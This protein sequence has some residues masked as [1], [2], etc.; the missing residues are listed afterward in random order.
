MFIIYPCLITFTIVA[1]GTVDAATGALLFA[2]AAANPTFLGGV[3]CP[4]R[5]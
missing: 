5:L 4:D 3:L 1:G 2:A